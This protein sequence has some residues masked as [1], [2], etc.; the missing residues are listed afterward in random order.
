MQSPKLISPS[1][2]TNEDK[3]YDG[4]NQPGTLVYVLI[5]VILCLVLIIAAL[6]FL[7]TSPKHSEK[8]HLQ[9]L[10]YNKELL[11]PTIISNNKL[12]EKKQLV[13]TKKLNEKIEIDWMLKKIDAENNKMQVWSKEDYDQALVFEVQAVE[14]DEKKEYGQSKEKYSEAIKKIDDTLLR[15][16][17]IF[18]GLLKGATGYLNKDKLDKAKNEFKKAESINEENKVIM[19]GLERINNR[20]EILQLYNQ[21]IEEDEK[22]NLVNS[23]EYLNKALLV[24]PEYIKLQNKLNQITE[25]KD[26]I[27]FNDAVSQT[28]KAIESGHINTAKKQLSN[29]KKINPNDPIIIELETQINDK[30]KIKKI[31]N[32][33]LKAIINESNEQ[34]SRAEN[35]YESILK[36]DSNTSF[37]IVGK[38]RTKYYSHLNRLLDAFIEKPQ[39]LQNNQVFI[40]SKKSLKYVQFEI[41]QKALI[42]KNKI[43]KLIKK[44]TLAKNII[45]AY[46]TLID[47]TIRSDNETQIM[48]YQVAK[49]GQFNEKKIQLRP[50]RYTIVGSKEG[51]RDFRNTINITTNDSKRF[52]NVICKEKI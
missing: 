9:E 33:Q 37:A 30:Y 11:L 4:N 5:G 6:V 17:E 2:N 22:G 36:I 34:W 14:Y 31:E 16:E 51:Y 21:A 50:G 47:I 28:L 32:L 46:S 43:P 49:F 25:K 27:D 7:P 20:G 15:K 10:N 42:K 45:D 19:R 29:A 13:P 40:K 39:R 24:E 48:I 8:K 52:I 23:I 41:N 44:I 1:D 3:N 18:Q 35:N 26:K 38:E 12:S